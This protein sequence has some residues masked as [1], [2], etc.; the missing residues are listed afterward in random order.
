MC[1]KEEQSLIILEGNPDDTIVLGDN[2]NNLDTE[3]ESEKSDV[4]DDIYTDEHCSDIYTE[5]HYS[6]IYT[7]EHYSDDEGYDANGNSFQEVMEYLGEPDFSDYHPMDYLL[8]NLNMP[9][10]QARIGAYLSIGRYNSDKIVSHSNDDIL[11][12]LSVFELKRSCKDMTSKILR[13]KS[14]V[15]KNQEK[16]DDVQVE[17]SNCFEVVL[18]CPITRKRLELPG[19]GFDCTHLE[20]F[21]IRA[22]LGLNQASLS[23]KS[24]IWNCP[25][26][27]KKAEAGKLYVD[28]YFMD[29]LAKCCVNDSVEF[30]LKS[31]L[32]WSVGNKNLN[33]RLIELIELN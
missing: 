14:A 9:P 17:D 23:H 1:L 3:N 10:R 7:D 31:G 30:E 22:Y 20:C 4:D 12:E 27:N 32:E 15:L 2:S 29:I 25:I 13:D 18:T 21:D 16:S 5:E 28:S 19:R 8:Y 11:L 33:K 24:L 26:C 6:D